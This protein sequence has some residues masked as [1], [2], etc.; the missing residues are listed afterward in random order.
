MK[1][2][3]RYA[4]MLLTIVGFSACNEDYKDWVAPQ[5]NPQL[6]PAI[7]VKAV[8]EAA[9]DV[10]IVVDDHKVGD[11]VE[12][13]KFVSMTA[14]EG[15]KVVFKSVKLDG[16]YSIP[17]VAKNNVIKVALSQLDSL[18]QESN[19]SRASVSRKLKL[20]IT[21]SAVTPQGEGLL[22]TGNEILINLKP[23][24]T[25]KLDP[26]G[27]YVVG[28]FKSWTAADALPFTKSATDPTLYVL[29]AEAPKD[30]TNF[31]I[32]PAAALVGGAVNWDMALGCKKDGDT[33]GE[34]FILW[35]NAQAIQ[36]AKA[37]KVI[38]TLDMTNFRYTVKGK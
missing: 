1:K 23:G 10:N 17:F 28:D 22:L 34:N 33:A 11:S 19:K 8:F 32:F 37:G 3:L 4:V 13:A 18:T 6:D 36:I 15:S 9:K 12:I 2:Q 24:A 7:S 38:I 29:E 21:A 20:T 26:D 31:K 5:S 14:A 30:G 16:N 27:Y 25:P 35:K